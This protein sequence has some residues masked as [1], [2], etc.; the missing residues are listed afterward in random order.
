MGKIA[1]KYFSWFFLFVFSFFFWF[2]FKMKFVFFYL[3][4]SFWWLC[5][6]DDLLYGTRCRDPM[7][8]IHLYSL[9]FFC[10]QWIQHRNWHQSRSSWRWTFKH[11]TSPYNHHSVILSVICIYYSFALHDFQCESFLFGAQ[12]CYTPSETI[13]HKQIE[14]ERKREREWE[15]KR[16]L[17]YIQWMSLFLTSTLKNYTFF[18]IVFDVHLWHLS[19]YTFLVSS[20]WFNNISNTIQTSGCLSYAFTGDWG[21]SVI[22]IENAYRYLI[23][24][25]WYERF[26]SE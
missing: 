20:S 2:S 13:A 9:N 19:F 24:D 22:H 17:L 14:S 5:S 11:S 10:S 23:N 21:R 8:H 1:S 25:V 12:S 3:L 26:Q 7:L 16:W 6:F 18:A 4:K 15:W